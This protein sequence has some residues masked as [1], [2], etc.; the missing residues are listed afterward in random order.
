MSKNPKKKSTKIVNIKGENL[1]IFWTSSEISI[2]IYDDIKSHKK[3]RFHSFSKKHS[4]ERPQGWGVEVGW[5]QIDP[6]AFLGL[7][8]VLTT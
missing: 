5:G 1:E 7:K 8:T 4:L 2:K 6:L 3:S